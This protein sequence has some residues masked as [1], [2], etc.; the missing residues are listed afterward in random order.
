MS[1]VYF[2]KGTLFWLYSVCSLDMTFRL[3]CVMSF[4]CEVIA[5]SGGVK[6]DFNVFQCTRPQNNKMYMNE[7]FTP[8]FFYHT[9]PNTLQTKRE[10]FQFLLD[11]CT[12]FADP[13][14]L[15][16]NKTMAKYFWS[17]FPAGIWIGF[18]EW[19]TPYPYRLL[20]GGSVSDSS[21]SMLWRSH[22]QCPI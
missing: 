8:Y 4:S 5:T 22:L 14:P 3:S 19:A 18:W 15:P 21:V 20:I 13:C 11:N 2:Q 10:V 6:D 7:P 12:P 1:W 9:L 17:P 16:T